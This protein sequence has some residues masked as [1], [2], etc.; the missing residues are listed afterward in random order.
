MRFDA[1]IVGAGLYG[2]TCANLLASRGAHVLVIDRRDHIAGNAHTDIRHEIPVHVYGA[3]IFHT[4]DVKVWEYVNRFASFNH[5]VNSP[6]ADYHGEIYNLPFNMN[7][8]ARLWGIRT[9]DEARA[10]IAEQT[11]REKKDF[12][13]RT[14]EEQAL[15]IAGRDIYEKLIKGYTE[16][17]WGRPCSEL[18]AFILKRVPFRFVYD[19]NYFNDPYQGIPVKGYTD[20]TARMLS[21][22]G[23]DG[24]IE[25]RLSTGY[26]DFVVRGEDALPLRES[27]D[28]APG[29]F[30][31]ANGDTAARIIFTGM[32]DDFFGGRLGALTY[33]SLSFETEEMT[34]IDDYQGVAVVNYTAAEIPYTRSIEH[35]HFVFGR[36]DG[37]LGGSAQDP[38]QLLHGT[39]VTREYPKAWKPGEEPYYPVNDE[40]NNARYEAYRALADGIPGLTFG[41]RL[42]KYR[43]YNMDQVIAEA[44]KDMAIV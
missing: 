26:E 33:R 14:V 10:V 42:G 31:L 9:P 4:A 36:R 3:H 25:V 29:D 41:G 43:Y 6:V 38:E 23:L 37:G 11:A 19:N 28:H 24:T 16:K 20:M 1:L 15:S 5:Y 30:R 8:F 2:A 34:G 21:D 17:Q 22:G 12:A 13:P 35:R 32:I 40:D 44:M 18:P 27:G 39:I 7:T